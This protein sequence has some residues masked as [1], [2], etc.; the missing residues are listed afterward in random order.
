MVPRAT[1]ANLHDVTGE[2]LA[3]ARQL[4][5]FSLRH[6][7][8]PRGWQLVAENVR[9]QPKL[10]VFADRTVLLGVLGFE[11]GPEKLRMCVTDVQARQTA[12]SVLAYHHVTGQAVINVAEHP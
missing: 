1:G 5:Q 10:V 2:V 8:A 3:R 9:D 12:L 11:G 7:A 4:G 6:H